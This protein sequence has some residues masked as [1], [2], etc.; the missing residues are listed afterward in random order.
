[1]ETTLMHGT[2]RWHIVS[3]VLVCGLLILGCPK[4]IRVES[5]REATGEI[6]PNGGEITCTAS[7]G[8]IYTLG[9]PPDAL[10]EGVEITMTPVTDI[11]NL[12]LSGGLAGAV[13]LA[14]PG[15][16]FARPATLT[17]EGA[18][19]PPAGQIAIG[20]G[21]EGDASSFEVALANA[22]NGRLT[23]LVQ[24]FSGSGVGFGTLQDVSGM[25]TGGF[26]NGTV[27]ES[28]AITLAS[29]PHQ[30]QDETAF[31]RTA[32]TAC[33]LLLLQNAT[34]DAEL[35]LAVSNYEIWARQLSFTL[36]FTVVPATSPDFANERQQAAQAAAPQLRAAVRSNNE[37]CGSAGSLSALANALFWQKQASIFG[38]DT[39]QER[40]D[41]DTVMLQ[42]NSLCASIQLEQAAMPFFLLVGFPHS[43]DLR[44]ELLFL[45]S[46]QNPQGGPFEVNLTA[47]G[48][49][50]QT[51]SGFT[52][53]DGRYTTV[54][55]ADAPGQVLVDVEA[56]LI[57]PG[58]TTATA[59]CSKFF[60][61]PTAS[62]LHANAIFD[63]RGT[64]TG[65]MRLHGQD[66]P[67]SLFFTQDGS[68]LGGTWELTD[69]DLHQGT[70]FQGSVFSDG[71]R[72]F[73]LALDPSVICPNTGG[74]WNTERNAI[75]ALGSDGRSF[76]ATLLGFDC[77]A[78]FETV[79]L[80]ITKQ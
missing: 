80:S 28:A 49:D 53:S 21:F 24:H 76:Q 36:G 20:F 16:A 48:A 58:T 23:V 32:F 56:C 40:L 59:I 46:S 18:A 72:D 19:A 6:G 11:V 15:L 37:L 78:S 8:T 5:D 73:K 65:T 1:M 29:T 2:L 79:Q 13:E 68:V 45:G 70:V 74:L 62:G 71:V 69:G 57:Q 61:T 10:A 38:V 41:L 30:P 26:C 35:V 67:I 54:I 52:A 27:L 31:F 22:D 34:S 51:P 4:N 17:I 44:I 63:L 33:I 64:W 9:I 39:L 25:P 12:P 3:V 50:L 77:H 75:V 14:P 60:G 47:F 7:N 66:H 42:V 55:T 43:L